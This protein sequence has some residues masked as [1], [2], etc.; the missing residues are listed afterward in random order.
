[1]PI[2][3]EKSDG[4]LLAARFAFMPNKLRYCGGDSNSELFEYAAHRTSDDGLKMMLKEFETMFPYLR[5]IAEANR[6]ADPFNYRVVEAY[7]IG[8]E[9]LENVSMNNFYRYLVDEQ[10]LKKKL[11][12]SVCEKVF[13]KIPVGAKPH[14]S[15]HVLNIPK[16][17]GNYPV[18]YTLRTMDECRISVGKIKPTDLPTYQP[19]D[20]APSFTKKV[21]VEYQPLAAAG[22]KL[23]L[24]EPVIREAWTEINN[25]AFVGE[26]KAGEWVAIHWGW[27]CDV[28]SQKQVENLNKW[29]NY[30]LALANLKI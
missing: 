7:W 22:N 9:L 8:N 21:L 24:G 5:L 29:T 1:M 14:H 27:V 6:I 20:L 4:A 17:T 18:D 15:F 16:R 11:K 23:I 12:L 19:T 25:K 26:L 3:T 10:K 28:L 13:G 30:N 2:I